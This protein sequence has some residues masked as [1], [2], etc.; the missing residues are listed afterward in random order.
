MILIRDPF[1][2]RIRP[3]AEPLQALPELPK[4]KQTLEE[5]AF[6][7]QLLGSIASPF[8]QRRR[9][10]EQYRH[11]LMERPPELAGI[12]EEALYQALPQSA[13]KALAP[14]RQMMMMAQMKEEREDLGPDLLITHKR[15]FSSSMT[16]FSSGPLLLRGSVIASEF[17]D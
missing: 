12:E 2:A 14:I 5:W 15:G 11:Y 8:L 16:F 1:T 13:K 9:L 4:W 3:P 10:A 17:R 6:I 7:P